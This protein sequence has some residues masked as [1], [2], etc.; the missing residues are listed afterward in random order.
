MGEVL[1]LTHQLLVQLSIDILYMRIHQSI[2]LW[3]Q[4]FGIESSE[5]ASMIYLKVAF[6]SSFH[7]NAVA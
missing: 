2:Y 3:V 1:Q 6:G 7:C 4:P 5:R